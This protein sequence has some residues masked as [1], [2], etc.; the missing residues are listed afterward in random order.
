MKTADTRCTTVT[1]R[2]NTDGTTQDNYRGLKTVFVSTVNLTRYASRSSVFVS[3]A[4]EPTPDRVPERDD[5]PTL[6][7]GIG[8][9]TVF[10][11][12]ADL[13]RELTVAGPMVHQRPF[14]DHFPELPTS[15]SQGQ[16]LVLPP[17]QV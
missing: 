3:L 8:C 9:S 5:P 12:V 16:H 13:P 6:T 7:V 10:P 15:R 17:L 4:L 14:S 1:R 2:R 11:V